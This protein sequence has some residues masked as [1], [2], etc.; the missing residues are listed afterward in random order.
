MFKSHGLY[1]LTRN[2]DTLAAVLIGAIVGILLILPGFLFGLYSAFIAGGRYMMRHGFLPDIMILN[3]FFYSGERKTR[4]F[5]DLSLID[6][7]VLYAV[8]F[9]ACL[10]GLYNG[11]ENYQS[12]LRSLMKATPVLPSAE[13]A[14]H[15]L[16]ENL[17]I[18]AGMR[19]PALEIVE[20]EALNAYATGRDSAEATITVTRGLL[21]RLSKDEIE[22]V[23]AHEL[24]H[25]RN[26]DTKV[27]TIVT[28]FGGANGER[29]PIW[30]RPILI[31]ALLFAFHVFGGFANGLDWI[32]GLFTEPRQLLGMAVLGIA[33]YFL[34][35][36]QTLPPVLS[37]MMT[38]AVS[39]SREFIADA[40][41]VA[42]TKNAPALISAL[43]KI[44][45]NDDLAHVPDQFFAMMISKPAT[46]T[47]FGHP[48]IAARIAEIRVQHPTATPRR[49]A[50]AVAGAFGRR[51]KLG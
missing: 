23:L 28:A 44:A 33:I 35:Y 10:L 18:A 47:S 13:P 29:K 43:G 2:N 17:T 16:L 1:G 14:L 21:K 22:A 26:K 27:M 37:S 6:L 32:P 38:E 49:A 42:L 9:G 30:K 45:G 41:A 20:T 5:F 46:R 8:V 51:A 31:L 12:R 36:L 24:V 48:S 25:I 4:V 34:G 15:K 11:L 39:T 50:L 40:G 19:M 3:A 7:D